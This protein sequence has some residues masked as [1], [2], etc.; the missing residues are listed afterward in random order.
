MLKQVQHDETNCHLEFDSGS[1]DLGNERR[2]L[3]RVQHDE[4][5]RHPELDSGS[6]KKEIK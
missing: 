2:M 5:N 6:F 4:T 1:H 3:K